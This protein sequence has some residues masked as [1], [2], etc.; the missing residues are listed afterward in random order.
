MK[1]ILF[2]LAALVMS[3]PVHAQ[4]QPI[5]VTYDAQIIRATDGDTVVIAA[6]YLPAPL[7]P[8]LAVRVFGVDTPEKS[9]RAKCESEKKRGEQSS[10]FT[11]LVIKSTK[12][13][14]VV[15]YDWDK[16]GGRVLGDI[17]LDGMSLRDLLIKNGFA[18]NYYGD[19]KQSWCN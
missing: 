12:K 2:V 10:E 17:I 14:Q 11:K 1:K 8:E 6:P 9:F 7:K 16:F 18:R 13:H 19:A 15:L 4:K 5:G 3:N